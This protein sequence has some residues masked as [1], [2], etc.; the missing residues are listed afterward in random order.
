[1]IESK[2]FE[3]SGQM[4]RLASLSVKLFSYYD[5]KPSD[6]A[7]KTRQTLSC[8]SLLP[9]YQFTSYNQKKS[10]SNDYTR[11]IFAF[12]MTELWN[13]RIGLAF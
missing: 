6:S 1:M 4:W 8:E 12:H 13:L 5:K 2:V 10:L 9:I 11:W 7:V 3:R